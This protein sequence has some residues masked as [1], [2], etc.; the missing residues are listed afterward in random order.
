MPSS[1]PAKEDS[2]VSLNPAYY[3]KFKNL[4]EEEK[5]DQYYRMGVPTIKRRRI[6][7]KSVV[8]FARYIPVYFQES[9]RKVLSEENEEYAGLQPTLKKFQDE[10]FQRMKEDPLLA[11]KSMD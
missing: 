7:L 10:V 8:N 6:Y 4:P 3:E 5:E 2:S 1:G 11:A 9:T